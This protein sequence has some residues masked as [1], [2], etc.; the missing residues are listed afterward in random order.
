MYGGLGKDMSYKY[1]SIASLQAN[2]RCRAAGTRYRRFWRRNLLDAKTL[3]WSPIGPLTYPTSWDLNS[4]FQKLS[5]MERRI[6]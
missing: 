4:P 1:P 6:G 2:V 3:T 5:G